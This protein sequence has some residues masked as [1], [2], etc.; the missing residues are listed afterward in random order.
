MSVW[1]QVYKS[2]GYTLNSTYIMG[3]KVVFPRRVEKIGDLSAGTE[4]LLYYVHL[5]QWFSTF[6]DAM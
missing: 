1:L 6:L 2:G 5:G 3:E 4:G